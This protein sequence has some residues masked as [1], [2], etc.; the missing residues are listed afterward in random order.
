MS[1]KIWSESIT[2]SPI[3][4]LQNESIV[5]NTDY[6]A[7]YNSIGGINNGQ[8]SLLYQSW[9][10]SQLQA[11]NPLSLNNNVFG[12]RHDI[13]PNNR[14]VN[15]RIRCGLKTVFKNRP[16]NQGSFFLN[17]W[18]DAFIT[19]HPRQ[20]LLPNFQEKQQQ[21]CARYIRPKQQ[22]HVQ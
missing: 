5:H 7:W 6:Y 14:Y 16:S 2:I 17:V 18:I 20:Q 19:M 12:I 9:M 8:T 1:C 13:I 3:S 15:Y 10:S 21:Q 4:R 22:R 11:L